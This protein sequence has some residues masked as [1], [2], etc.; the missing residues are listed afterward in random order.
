MSLFLKGSGVLGVPG[1]LEGRCLV[2][3]C[4]LVVHLLHRTHHP[5]KLPDCCAAMQSD[6]VTA[7]DTFNMPAMGSIVCSTN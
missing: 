3:V 5:D 7:G 6:G 2:G 1:K 4:I